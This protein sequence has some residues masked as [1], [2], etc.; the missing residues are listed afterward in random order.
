MNVEDLL[1]VI[2]HAEAWAGEY[3]FAVPVEAADVSSACDR[4]RAA[5][6][7]EVPR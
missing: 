4:L 5:I 3:G 7:Q 6:A 2:E 1:I